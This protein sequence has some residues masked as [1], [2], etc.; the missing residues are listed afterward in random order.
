MISDKMESACFERCSFGKFTKASGM[1]SCRDRISFFDYVRLFGQNS[2]A[3]IRLGR[4]ES[5]NTSAPEKLADIIKIRQALE[6][7]IT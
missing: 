5:W 3:S 2:S 6:V 1:S 4:D 7:C